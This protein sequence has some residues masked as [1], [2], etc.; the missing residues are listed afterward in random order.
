MGSTWEG[1]EKRRAEALYK[2]RNLWLDRKKMSGFF[3]SLA[4]FTFPPQAIGCRG[5][6]LWLPRLPQL[7]QQAGPLLWR[8]PLLPAQIGRQVWV[9]IQP[10]QR[11]DELPFLSGAQ[12]PQPSGRALGP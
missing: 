6:I 5:H 12:P 2:S 8:G 1:K 9:L 11:P 3:F 7:A 10:V 4:I